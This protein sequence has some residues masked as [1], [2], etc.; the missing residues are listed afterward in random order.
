MKIKIVGISWFWRTCLRNHFL[1]WHINSSNKFYS[2]FNTGN[3]STNFRWV[4]TVTASYSVTN[5][6]VA[7]DMI[8]HQC[9]PVAAATLWYTLHKLYLGHAWPN[10]KKGLWPSLNT[11]KSLWPLSC[12]AEHCSVTINSHVL[13]YTDNNMLT[14]YCHTL[15][16]WDLGQINPLIL[17]NMIIFEL[18]INALLSLSSP[19]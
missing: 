8:C 16:E 19:A 13:V 6:T 4:V 18:V 2:G 3:S 1:V 7:G 11:V 5:V 9:W 10:N 15:V 12:L 14:M 17:Y